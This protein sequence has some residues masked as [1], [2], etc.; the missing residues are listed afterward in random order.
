MYTVAAF[1]KFSPLS[2]DRAPWLRAETE[3]VC[4]DNHVRGLILLGTEGINATVCGTP[5]AVT[6]LLGFLQSVPEIGVFDARL[7]ESPFPVFDRLKVEVRDEIVT[8]KRPD[9][10]PNADT[11][12]SH[13]SP[14]AWHD[15]LTTG[16]GYLLLDTRN[17]FEVAIGAFRG[18]VDPKTRDFADLQT[19]VQEQSIPR[20]TPVLMYCTGG[21]R[22]EKA[23][24]L[25]RQ[26]GFGSVRQLQG[27]ILNYLETF[28]DTGA[29]DGECFVFDKRVAVDAALNPSRTY[30]LCPFCG[31]PASAAVTCARCGKSGV[32]C[33]GCAGREPSACGQDC[34]YHLSFAAF[35]SAKMNTKK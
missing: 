13:L 11:D 18:A 20:D 23:A 5:D 35:A 19:W 8:L 33:G 2:A 22:C 4:R 28:G 9:I 26:E 10:V 25:L 14:Q 1:Y 32:L 27:G 29:F 16:T 34:A 7:S 24:I 12:G 15:A 3:A 21:I 17:G 6:D 31:D 30:T